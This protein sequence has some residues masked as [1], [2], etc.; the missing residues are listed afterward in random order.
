M[1]HTKASTITTDLIISLAQ[2]K[3]AYVYLG[4]G[5]SPRYCTDTPE[6]VQVITQLASQGHG[7]RLHTQIDALAENGSSCWPKVREALEEAGAFSS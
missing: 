2:G 6:F 7:T 3:Y 4:D 5:S 1:A